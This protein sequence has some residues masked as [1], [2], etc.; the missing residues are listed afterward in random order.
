MNHRPCQECGVI[1]NPRHGLQ[2]Y[3]EPACRNKQGNRRNKARR[4]RLGL[5]I[6][7]GSPRRPREAGITRC[8]YC[9]DK[10]ESYMRR[11]YRVLKPLCRGCN[12]RRVRLFPQ[13]ILCS[14]C[15]RKLFGRMG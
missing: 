4:V 10:L 8:R 9:A 6:S 1:F 11:C 3:C 14:Q 7:C 13:E 5:C 12:E 2:K 15:R